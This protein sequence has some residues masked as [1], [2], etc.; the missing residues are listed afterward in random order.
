MVQ[1]LFLSSEIEFS[2]DF[3]PAALAAPSGTHLSCYFCHPI[4]NSHYFCPDF[5]S[6]VLLVCSQPSIDFH[7]IQSKSQRLQKVPQVPACSA[8][9]PFRP[10][11]LLLLHSPH[12]P[13]LGTPSSLLVLQHV[14]Q[15]LILPFLCVSFS[16]LRTLNL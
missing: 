5:Y 14:R 11:L 9:F 12:H 8:C 13:V 15:A 6:N 4:L 16:L 2:L 1:I 10:P 3:L 7:L